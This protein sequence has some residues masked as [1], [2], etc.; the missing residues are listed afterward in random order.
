MYDATWVQHN[1]KFILIYLYHR[2]ILGTC[3]I[4]LQSSVYILK[5]ENW[6]SLF[7]VKAKIELENL[8]QRFAATVFLSSCWLK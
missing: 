6:K 1:I 5:L 4:M 2:C 3:Y 7:L 8:K